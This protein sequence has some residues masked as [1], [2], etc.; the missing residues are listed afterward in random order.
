LSFRLDATDGVEA[1]S[2]TTNV[3]IN[4]A[5]TVSAGSDQ[6]VLPGEGV[7]LDGSGS[8][9]ADGDAITYKWVQTAGPSVTLSSTSAA[10]PTFT[11]STSA[12]T[13]YTFRL[14][15]SDGIETPTATVRVIVNRPPVAD[16]GPNQA[17]AAGSLVTLDGSG[18][19]DPDGDPLTYQWVQKTLPGVTLSSAT[20]AKPTFTAPSTLGVKLI[21]ELTVSDGAESSVASVQVDVCPRPTLTASPPSLG[22]ASSGSNP[23]GRKIVLSSNSLCGASATLAAFTGDGG[24]WLALGASSVFVPGEFIVSVDAA[25]LAP[26]TYLGKIV[27]TAPDA[28]NSPLE[29]PVTL[30]VEAPPT[31]TAGGGLVVCG[32]LGSGRGDSQHGPWSAGPEAPLGLLVLV[33]MWRRRRPRGQLGLKALTAGF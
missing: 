31:E 32:G 14:E 9:D 30:T 3:T 29:V 6:R 22:F 2:S 4:R 19:T 21:F 18:S 33:L 16:A 23:G 5:P 27:V 25:R 20:A 26:G 8:S 13:S 24:A 10:K 28:T 15:V 1:A 17:I 11:A 12:G 7:T